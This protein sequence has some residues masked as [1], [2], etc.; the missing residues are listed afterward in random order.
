MGN[1]ASVGDSYT[2]DES[3]ATFQP[4][5]NY[6]TKTDLN[7][8]ATTATNTFQPKG[9]YATITDL[10]NAATTATNTF[11]TKAATTALVNTN[12]LN[13]LKTRTLWCADGDFCQVPA[14]KKGFTNGAMIIDNNT[15]KND[16]AG[17][18][19]R[20]HISGNERLYLLNKDGVIVG[21]EWGGN[22]N[23][24]VQG[25]VYVEG[26]DILAELNDLKSNSVRKDKKY[27]IRS[28]RGGY[29]SDQG[30]WKGKPQGADWWETMYID[31]LPF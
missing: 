22:G 9:D 8:A 20:V 16:R 29:L 6:A 28:A 23:L 24:Q 25:R 7:N 2:K 15:I 26:R 17:E 1:Y 11:Q 3:D 30:G 19:G 31:E 13:D 5:G 4:K 10:N 27:G 18:A 12:T 14:G 21:K